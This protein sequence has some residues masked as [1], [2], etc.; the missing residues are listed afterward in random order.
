MGPILLPECF[1]SPDGTA[2]DPYCVSTQMEREAFDAKRDAALD[3]LSSGATT[4]NGIVTVGH[5]IFKKGDRVTI[6]GTSTTRILLAHKH[7]AGWFARLL[8]R[9][10]RPLC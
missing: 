6:T 10:F 2:I 3:W 1:Q 7:R 4:K 5:G 9:I 8:R